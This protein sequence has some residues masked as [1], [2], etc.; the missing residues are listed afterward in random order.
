MKNGLIFENDELIYYKNGEPYHA[1]VVKDGEDIYYISS[2]GRAIKGQHVIHREMTNDLLERG[3]YTFGDDY[4][5]IPGSFI[6]PEKRK[7]KHKKRRSSVKK[8]R[9]TPFKGK[10]LLAFGLM[11]LILTLVLLVPHLIDTAEG[12]EEPTL[13]SG[14]K[15]VSVPELGE[16]LLCSGAAKQLYDGQITTE[17]AVAEGAAYRP[18]NFDYSLKGSGGTLYLSEDPDMENARKYI[19]PANATRISIDNLKTGT[20]YYWQVVTGTEQYAGQFETVKSTRFLSIPG[21]ENTR[22]I[23]GYENLDGKTVKQGMLIRGSEI[24]GLVVNH[25]FI[26]RDEIGS[27]QK[28]FGFAYEFD[29]RSP[30]VYTGDY[31]SRLGDDVGH[32]FYAAP[33]Y[34]QIFSHEYTENLKNIFTDLANPENYPMYMHC[35]YGADRTGTVIFLLQGVLNMSQEQMVREYQMT[36]FSEY[37]AAES[38]A[39]DVVIEGFNAYEGDT[40]QERI[41]RFLMDEVGVTS[42]EIESI[43]SILLTE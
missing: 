16:V 35:T 19:L 3:V 25:Y 41:V 13:G 18:L 23:G 37:T 12:P 2:H 36:G 14:Q 33:Q 39:M 20:T 29:L 30:G 28:T 1:G 38:T 7:Q 32:S 43:R 22:D 34:G 15:T 26:P 9:K 31:K 10:V 21:A 5:L 24:D 6:P 4:K 8:A 11:L 40:L 17:A 27:V 42:Y